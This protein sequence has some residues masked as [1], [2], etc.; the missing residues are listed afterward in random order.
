MAFLNVGMIS[1]SPEEYDF[2]IVGGGTAGCLIANRLSE[3]ENWNVLLLEAG[4]EENFIQ[5]VPLLQPLAETFPFWIYNYEAE[6]SDSYALSMRS[7]QIRIPNGKVL[8]GSSTINGMV[9]NRGNKNDFD[10]W[11]KLG[12]TG[13]SYDNVLPYFSKHENT[14]ISGLRIKK[15]DNSTDGELYIARPPYRSPLSD[16][17]VNSG[18]QNGYP[19]Y[20]YNSHEQIGFTY[21][22]I[23]IKNGERL[24]SNNAFLSPVRHRNNLIVK[25]DSMVTRILIDRNETKAYGVE[26]KVF[27]LISF[28]ALAKKEVIVCAGAL[29]S[30]QLLMLSGIGPRN[31]LEKFGI[32]VIQDSKVGYNYRDQVTIL[33]LFF[34]INETIGFRLYD[35]IEDI[36]YISEYLLTKN[37]QFS[38]PAGFEGFSFLDVDGNDNIPDV[39][40][41]FGSVLLPSIPF[42]LSPLGPLSDELNSFYAPLKNKNGFTI[43]PFLLKPESV[44]RLKLK[45]SNVFSNPIYE[46]NYFA[47]ERDKH[48]LIKGIKEAVRLTNTDAFKKYDARLFPEPLPGCR[49]NT[50]GSY[51]Y[52]ECCIKHSTFSGHHPTGT[53]K[54][55]PISDPDAVVDPSLRVIGIKNL[56]VA[57]ASVMPTLTSGHLMAPVYMIAEKA[58]DIVKKDWLK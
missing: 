58:A 42:F 22:G 1:A 7:G 27:G 56:R 28:Q 45:D 49:N 15:K 12:N 16:A 54:M 9:Y 46:P 5:D 51:S 17:F 14:I 48:T 53:C 20:D 18:Q 6:K 25:T 30:P 35:I 2:I 44:G 13:W 4:G 34:T 43:L 10:V 57:D 55:G 52:W 29:R 31:H 47:T 26:Y 24:S 39:E 19:Y 36:K 21:T 11:E 23:T 38:V 8:G 33:N 32:A 50:F 41:F 37:G 3:I 40:L